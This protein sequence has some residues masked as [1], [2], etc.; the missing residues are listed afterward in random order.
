MPLHKH[1]LMVI[2]FAAIFL[3]ALA[4]PARA[5]VFVVTSTGST[6]AGTLHQ[7]IVDANAHPGHDQIHFNLTGT[8][9]F[10]IQ[11]GN[12]PAVT[13]PVDIDGTTQP[14]YNGRPL[15]V[16]RGGAGAPALQLTA[17]DSLIRGLVLNGAWDLGIVVAGSNNRI[18]SCY[19][20][21]DANGR[22][23]AVTSTSSNAIQLTGTGNQIG[24]PGQGNVLAA[25]RASVV[26]ESG[27]TD[28]VIQGNMIGLN[29]AG[30][31]GIAGIGYGIQVYGDRTRIGGTEPGAGNV[32]G[33]FLNHTG[34]WLLRADYCTIQ[35]NFIGTNAAG[36]A[37]AMNRWGIAILGMS[38]TYHTR[39]CL[40]G[41]TEPGAGNFFGGN[42]QSAIE[43]AG[44]DANNITIQG[45]YFGVHPDGGSTVPNPQ[46]T[47]MIENG[48]NNCLIGGTEP[49]AGNVIAGGGD[50]G[51]VLT[52]YEDDT[53]TD[54]NVYPW[55][56]RILGNR[57]YGNSQLNIDL[58]NHY[59]NDRGPTANDLLDADSGPNGK[60]N[61]PLI[62]DCDYD[63]EAATVTVS[64]W[65]HS[66]PSKEYRLEFFAAGQ[67]PNTLVA[68]AERY[69]GHTN[70]TTDSVGDA[71]F[72]ITFHNAVSLGEWITATAT[73]ADG[74]TSE[75]APAVG[76]EFHTGVPADVWSVYP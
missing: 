44:L 39:H 54:D 55:A 14:G 42:W 20:G 69:L 64:G 67:R 47:I 41:G 35:G 62:Q 61:Y 3:T 9:P 18:L 36:T 11:T 49:G 6:G 43:G 28:N 70:V 10:V 26:V 58:A 29:A 52:N 7:A 45:N 59:Q 22:N 19:V 72:E 25:R 27:A 75:L 12:L 65:L 48:M 15:V 60:Q 21:T 2:W 4:M 56:I 33:G 23:L 68:D 38:G 40:I 50:Y 30:D 17:N 74:N 51:I 46:S 57:I 73:S 5:D 32:I 16:V 63:H 31:A 53:T 24:L 76:V 8:A 1:T 71:P 66:E 34:I 37:A 13:D